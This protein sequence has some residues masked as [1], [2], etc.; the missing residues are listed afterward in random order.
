MSTG[1]LVAIILV[2]AAA[3]AVGINVLVFSLVRRAIDRTV[4]ELASEGIVLDSGRVRVTTR[5]R[6]FRASGIYIGAGIRTG[7]GRL[8]L[9]KQRLVILPRG[10]R[11]LGP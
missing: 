7:G 10:R 6:D 1:T 8:V 4:A 5:Y 11:R 2:G 3:L 9:T